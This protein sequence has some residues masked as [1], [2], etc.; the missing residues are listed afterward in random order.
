MTPP[1]TK[2]AD[3]PLNCTVLGYGLLIFF[4]KCGFLGTFLLEDFD[5]QIIF[6][7]SPE[8]PSL[9]IFHILSTIPCSLV[10]REPLPFHVLKSKDSSSL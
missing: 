4:G 9:A 7:L 6:T 10:S 3:E 1:L 8:F 2:G 5:F